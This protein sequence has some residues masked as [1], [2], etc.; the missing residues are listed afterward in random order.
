MLRLME[1]EK[2][3]KVL[4]LNKRNEGELQSHI[5]F[6]RRDFKWKNTSLK[7]QRE[8]FQR[9]ILPPIVV[10]GT[11]NVQRKSSFPL[12]KIHF[13]VVENLDMYLFLNFS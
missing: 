12:K 2:A 4:I 7:K 9:T 3:E 5:S 8:N 11:A 10:S 13:S 1:R 6:L